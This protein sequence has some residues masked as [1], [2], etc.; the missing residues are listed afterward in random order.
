MHDMQKI[1]RIGGKSYEEFGG[2]VLQNAYFEQTGNFSLG[3]DRESMYNICIWKS[4]QRTKYIQ[5]REICAWM[6]N[7]WTS[8][9][10]GIYTSLTSGRRRRR[11]ASHRKAGGGAS[12]YHAHV[13][14]SVPEENW[15]IYGMERLKIVF[16]PVSAERILWRFVE[17]C[18][19]KDAHVDVYT[20]DCIEIRL[21]IIKILLQIILSDVRVM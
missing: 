17:F 11:G 18:R 14:S 10:R 4:V 8:S 2:Y 6:P 15:W 13:R 19:K 12:W 1:L 9:P 20:W 21:R 5:I 16:L 3:I 7:T